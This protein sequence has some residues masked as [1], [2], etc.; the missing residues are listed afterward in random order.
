[1]HLGDFEAA[2]QKC[3][4]PLG[5][6][7]LKG[8]ASQATRGGKVGGACP[9][10]VQEP[11]QDVGKR[12][13]GLKKA[14]SGPAR[15]A[16]PRWADGWDL[17]ACDHCSANPQ[18]SKQR[19]GAPSGRTW[20][21]GGTGTPD[22]G[23]TRGDDAALVNPPALAPHEADGHLALGVKCAGTSPSPGAEPGRSHPQTQA[24][25]SFQDR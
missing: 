22:A 7:S 9:N 19:Q 15:V 1:M 10:A 11:G 5:V 3:T 2:A 20:T 13:A 21:A 23:R 6:Q 25:S 16:P 24:A 18:L 14:R 8:K 4:V 12:T 17:T